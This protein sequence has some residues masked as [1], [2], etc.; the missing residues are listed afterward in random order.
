M[1]FQ[2]QSTADLQTIVAKLAECEEQL[3]IAEA[4]APAASLR[5]HLGSAQAG[6]AELVAKLMPLR[7]ER[8]QLRMARE[9]AEIVERER[10]EAAKS[11]G[12]AS[13]VRA[14][15][16]AVGRLD[17]EMHASAAA[18]EAMVRSFARAAENARA[19]YAL[20]PNAK[21]TDQI[22]PSRLARLIQ[23]EIERAG[24]ASGVRVFDGHTI[25]WTKDFEKTAT[26]VIV[27]FDDLLGLAA[28]KASLKALMPQNLS[29]AD[30]SPAADAAAPIQA[31]PDVLL[32][33]EA[34]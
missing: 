26:G 15:Q 9:A 29:A 4:A 32:N 19:I 28:I 8:D 21:I 5:I 20:W 34:A 25:P 7:E 17:K 1:A 12:L 6:D 14:A 27:A 31:E 13:R 24:R 2:A 33:D 11:R 3:A 10:K 18:A 16:Q 30:Q 22:T 23:A